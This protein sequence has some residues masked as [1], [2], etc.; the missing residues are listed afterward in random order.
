MRAQANVA[1]LHIDC[2]SRFDKV[3]MQIRKRQRTQAR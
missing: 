2:R 1:D 3:A